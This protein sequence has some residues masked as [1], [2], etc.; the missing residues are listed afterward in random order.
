RPL[1]RGTSR[2]PP[3][4]RAMRAF[5][6]RVMPD[7]KLFRW[8]LLGAFFAKPLAPVLDFFG[9]DRLAAML[10]LAPA[11]FPPRG[12]RG[13]RVFA[14]HGERRGRV[15]LLTGCAASVLTPEINAAA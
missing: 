14:A 4:D 11:T 6:A 15:A 2:R 13:P 5:V 3:L 9:L 7:P 10:R 12:E 8:S 1:V